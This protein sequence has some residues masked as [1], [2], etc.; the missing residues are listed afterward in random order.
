MFVHRRIVAVFLLVNGWLLAPSASADDLNVV[1]L[2]PA[3]HA[4][5]APIG[6][7]ISITFDR[8]V[9]LSSVNANTF[10]VFGRISGPA[11]GTYATSNGGLTV[12]FTPTVAF[13]AGEVVMVGLVRPLQATD[14]SLMR[15]AGYYYVFNTRSRPASLAYTEI[16]TLTN[17]TPFEIANDIPT[18]IYGAMSTDLNHDGFPDLTTVNED[19]DDLRV[20]LHTGNPVTPYDTFETPFPISHEAS[21]NEP[22][23]FNRD[24]HADIAVAASSTDSAWIVLGDGNGGFSPPGQEIDIGSQPH[25]VATLDVEGDGDMDVV[26]SNSGSNDLTMLLNDGTGDFDDVAPVTLEAGC[27][28][29]YGITAADMNN[30]GILDLVVGCRYSEDVR[31]LRGNGNGTFTQMTLQDAGGLAWMVTCGDVNGDGHMDVTVANSQSNNGSVLLGNGAF[32]LALPMI[33]G[34]PGH[35]VAT[36]IGDLDGDGDLDW[37]LS[38]F[39]AGVWRVFTNNG[40]GAFSFLEQVTAIDNPSC[41]IILDFDGD[42]DLDLALTD[43]IADVIKL[44]RNGG[45]NPLGDFNNDLDVDGGD[46]TSFAGCFSGPGGSIAASCHHGDFD[47]DGD[48]DCSDWSSFAA[49]WTAGGLPPELPECA[50][51]EVPA[52]SHRELVW[53]AALLAVIG[54]IVVRRVP[55]LG[56]WQ[57]NR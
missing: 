24:G 31:I 29:E 44:R 16:A 13:A 19:S 3:R 21:P 8:A 26:T 27:D 34:M 43:E 52:M 22:G 40:S 56:A 47:G 18:R 2:Q 14:G 10:M 12:T 37:V 28:G 57:R 30:D 32:G 20:L 9:L 49:A 41:G 17:R 45:I 36:D 11:A 35:T 42:R 51:S 1:T 6:T 33:T 46:Y 15:A 38:S 39:G 23:D 50:L 4:L 48:V 7:A 55:R 54:S 5:T 25:G 53:L